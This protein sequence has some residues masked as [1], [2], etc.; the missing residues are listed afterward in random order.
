MVLTLFLLGAGEV[1]SG[2]ASVAKEI[3]DRHVA[4]IAAAMPPGWTA[5]RSGD[6]VISI[7]RKEAAPMITMVPNPPPDGGATMRSPELI[8]FAKP[9]I[10]K[11]ELKERVK[12]N[13]DRAKAL[14]MLESQL[15]DLPVT[16]PSVDDAGRRAAT[17]DQQA[18]LDAYKAVFHALP[19]YD[20]PEL[21]AADASFEWRP[22]LWGSPDPAV[23]MEMA[24]V[25]A[26]VV[27]LYAQ[28]P[29]Q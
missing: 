19:Q 13:T 16:M 12:K 20:V 29:L 21:F 23:V 1:G 26:L 24:R 17:P 28:A 8:L 27:A 4:R 5:W 11:V 25:K 10:S 6:G 18:R 14:Q 22:P 2:E 7:E 9:P 15:R 3:V